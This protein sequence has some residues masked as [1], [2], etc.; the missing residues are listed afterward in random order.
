MVLFEAAVEVISVADVEPAAGICQNID[1][2]HVDEF[3]S[4]D[5]IRT[6]SLAV[7]SRPLYR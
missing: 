1:V 3:G 7:N 4:R 2:V 5:R 6:C